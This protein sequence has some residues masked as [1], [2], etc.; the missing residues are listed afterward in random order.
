MWF[1]TYDIVTVVLHIHIR[2]HI[3]VEK[4]DKCT[5]RLTHNLYD[6]LSWPCLHILM[7]TII[8]NELVGLIDF[9]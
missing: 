6:D 5:L 7:V 9:Y 3:L 1:V 8:L 2:R 4:A